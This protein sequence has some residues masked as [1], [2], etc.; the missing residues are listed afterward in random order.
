MYRTFSSRVALRAMTVGVGPAACVGAF[1]ATRPVIRCDAPT[2]A[3]GPPKRR[4]RSLDI[5]PDTV[6]Q[7]SSGSVAGSLSW[8]TR[9]PMCRKLTYT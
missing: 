8:R 1:V 9:P 6:R 2:L 5:S 7:L 4:Q 3:T